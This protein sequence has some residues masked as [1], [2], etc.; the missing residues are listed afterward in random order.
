[1]IAIQL[2]VLLF[3]KL[4][5]AGGCCP[6]PELTQREALW[7]WLGEKVQCKWIMLLGL[8]DMITE[9]TNVHGQLV[10]RI[11]YDKAVDSFTSITEHNKQ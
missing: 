7:L 3:L 10:D 5:N 8:P 9:G 2:L 1:M 11:I 4:Q 6:L